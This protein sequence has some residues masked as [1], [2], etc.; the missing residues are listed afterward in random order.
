MAVCETL[1]VGAVVRSWWEPITGRDPENRCPAAWFLVGGAPELMRDAIYRAHDSGNVLP[2]D[3]VYAMAR[4]V[5]ISLAEWGD[6]LGNG[7]GT[8]ESWDVHQDISESLVPVYTSE[9]MDWLRG[10]PG[11]VDIVNQTREEFG[12]DGDL[13]HDVAIGFHACAY[14]MC[15][16]FGEALSAWW[17]S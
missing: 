9:L 12:T 7:R 14:D 3:W 17:E 8:W 6:E 15:V 4:D 10:Y 13:V 11:A 1:D 5:V 2:S 16:I